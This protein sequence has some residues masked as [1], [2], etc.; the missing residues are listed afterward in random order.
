M[1][2]TEPLFGVE[3]PNAFEVGEPEKALVPGFPI[4]KPK[5]D[6]ADET[7]IEWI[8]KEVTGAEKGHVGAFRSDAMEAYKFYN[9]KQ[10]DPIDLDLLKQFGRPHNAFNSLQKFIRF[11]SGVERRSPEA[12]IFRALEEY[13][14]EAMADS[15]AATRSYEW[16][17]RRGHSANET[18][19]AFFDVLVGG[20]GWVDWYL[21]TVSEARPIPKPQRVPLWEMLWAES[22]RAN[23]EA[24]RWRA[25]EIEMSWRDVAQRWPEMEDTAKSLAFGSGFEGRPEPEK[26]QY[27]MPYVTTE[28]FAGKNGEKRKAG[29]CKI[30]EFQ[31][32]DDTRGFAFQDPLDGQET[33]LERKE[34]FTY[35]RKLNLLR[36]PIEGE[37]ER[38]RRLHKKVILLE[39][40]YQLG[41]MGRI[42]G[43]RFSL[44][45]MTGQ[46]DESDRQWYGFIRVLM[47]PQRYANKFFN[48]LI[49]IIGH[50]A[51]GGQIYEEG[52]VN[53][54]QR[55][56]V[57]MTY[58]KP[59][60]W[61]EVEKGALSENRIRAKE[62]PT[63]AAGTMEILKY[64]TAS[65]ENVSGL[66]PDAM[67]IGGGNVPGVTGKRRQHAGLVLFSQEF[68]N[69][70]QFREEEGR[71]VL[72][73][74]GVIAD[75][76]TIGPPSP[77]EPIAYKLD[78]KVFKREYDI[79]LDDTE[80]D[81]T[82]RDKYA[83]QI[84]AIAPTMMRMGLFQ[85][86]MFDYFDWPVRIREKV[87]ATMKQ[88]E[89]MKQYALQHGL[90]LPGGRGPQRDPKEQAAKIQKLNAD[91]MLAM[92]KAEATAK[93]GK[94]KNLKSLIAALHEAQSAD[95]EK[96]EHGHARRRGII[97]DAALITNIV[98]PEQP[99]RGQPPQ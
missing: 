53:P 60:S 33:W 92:A 93:S 15:E 67:G 55:R 91:A 30:L 22:E 88:Q 65:M 42:P 19:R 43:N 12:V 3:R 96:Q 26:V 39:R 7:L 62:L 58:A 1:A 61:T 79:Y 87:K 83:E 25:R 5:Q 45:C 68:D 76:R 54:K 98:A 69:L 27:I 57:E 38:Y 49:E 17:A 82:I 95:I 24:T 71:I 48:Q 20:M 72:G 74:L 11:V 80:L 77:F 21:D 84:M 94:V 2:A 29:K 66:P 85:P 6:D 18:S 47:D 99:N 40:K 46:W 70:S 34:F 63:I 10:I 32:W 51:K 73:F 56:Q 97:E 75:G 41:D 78:P 64:S 9:G 37:E 52:A 35:A 8:G 86:E 44:N 13:D 31:W 59:G 50:Q 28:N 89:Q 4:D 90:P 36:Y 16:A 23:L 81:P 14:P